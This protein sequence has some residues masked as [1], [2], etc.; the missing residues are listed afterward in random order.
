MNTE[1]EFQKRWSLPALFAHTS[2]AGIKYS[3][4]EVPSIKLSLLACEVENK[5]ALLFGGHIFFETNSSHLYRIVKETVSSTTTK[6]WTIGRGGFYAERSK[7][8]LSPAEIEY[9]LLQVDKPFYYGRYITDPVAKIIV[10]TG[11]ILKANILLPEAPL[12]LTFLEH[13]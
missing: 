9:S 1:I 7:F 4:C 2:E 11:H 6:A 13:Q 5:N 3:A 12:V 8:F 10:V